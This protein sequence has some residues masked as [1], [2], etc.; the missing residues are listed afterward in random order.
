MGKRKQFE[1]GERVLIKTVDVS[2]RGIVNYEEVELEGEIINKHDLPD[3]AIYDVFVG[4]KSD[5]HGTSYGMT[6]R[7]YE[8]NIYEHMKNSLKGK[9]KKSMF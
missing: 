8:C 4:E 3:D 6:F 5:E 1:I 2:K 7:R 9:S